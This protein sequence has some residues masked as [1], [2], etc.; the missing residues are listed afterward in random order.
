MQASLIK[1]RSLA[2]TLFVPGC[3]TPTLL[4]LIEEPFDQVT[5]DKD[6]G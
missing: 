4:D 6:A 5:P 1:A 3:D 2:A